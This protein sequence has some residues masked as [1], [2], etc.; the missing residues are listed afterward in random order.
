H[1]IDESRIAFAQQDFIRFS[2]LHSLS[3]R[4]FIDIGCGSG[5]HSVGAARLGAQVTAIDIDPLNVQNT[6]RLLSRFAHDRQWR[7][8]TAS[9]VDDHDVSQLSTTDLVYSWGVLHHTGAMWTALANTAR[10]VNHE[11]YLYLMLYR[12]DHCA[13]F[14]QIVRRTYTGSPRWIQWLMRNG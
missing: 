1:D 13:K 14:W 3:G 10:L 4:T 8:F 2:G 12:D 9:I 7:V 5:L 11:G 6:Q